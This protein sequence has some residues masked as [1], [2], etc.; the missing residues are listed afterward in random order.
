M[1]SP[2]DKTKGTRIMPQSRPPKNRR[3]LL[4]TLRWLRFNLEHEIIGI[5]EL[6]LHRCVDHALRVQDELDEFLS[7]VGRVLG[8]HHG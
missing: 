2:E 4:E 3:P 8:H 7:S 5:D 6:E 1:P